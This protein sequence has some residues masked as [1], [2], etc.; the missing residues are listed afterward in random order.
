MKS[1]VFLLLLLSVVSARPG[2]WL[3]SGAVLTTGL[4]Q[5]P[6]EQKW[7]KVFDV[8]SNVV[9]QVMVFFMDKDII[10]RNQANKVMEFLN[11]TLPYTTDSTTQI[12]EGHFDSKTG[13]CMMYRILM[14]QLQ[15]KLTVTLSIN[16]LYKG[17]CK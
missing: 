8:N 7:S 16:P 15:K 12:G 13:Y 5:V 17:V 11:G 10:F 3:K 6:V 9:A 4:T 14:V 1:V 2:R